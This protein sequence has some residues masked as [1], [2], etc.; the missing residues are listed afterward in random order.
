MRAGTG[1]GKF[2]A[3]ELA[4]YGYD[5]RSDVG[6]SDF[7]V[8]VA[9]IDPRNK[10][11]FVLG[12]LCDGPNNFSVKDRNILQVQTLKRGNWN[13]LRLNTV[14]YYNNPKRELK[15]I[16]DVLDRLT[17]GEKR[18][19]AWLS[20]YKRP[21]KTVKATA[22]ETSAFV[23]GG[24]H[25]P[26]II[27]R[28]KE[29]VASEE[30]ISRAFLKKRCLQ[31]FGIERSGS[32]VEARL[33]A[34]IDSCGFNRDRAM[35]VDYF[36]RT[37]RAIQLGRFRVEGE[38]PAVRKS[39][40]DFTVYEVVSL[41]KGALEDRV[42]LYMDEVAAVVSGVFREIR[43]TERALVFLRDCISYGEE[44]GVF[45]RSVSDRITLA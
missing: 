4:G 15:R 18:G 6:A 13:I 43:P 22:S 33:D 37:P 27:A 34:L 36:Y 8:D 21:Y 16:K 10:R 23:T 41:V 7:K 31:S 32:K 45:V 14:N 42:A 2:I 38:A 20:K 25:D 11:R 35:G 3:A 12:I 30:P 44:K 5:C 28:L 1:I 40:E 39:E 24:E 17:G 26:A 9:V 19:D 29:I